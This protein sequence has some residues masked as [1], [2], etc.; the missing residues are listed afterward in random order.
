[1]TDPS[2]KLFMPAQYDVVLPLGRRDGYRAKELSYAQNLRFLQCRA[3][4]DKLDL[5]CIYLVNSHIYRR[6]FSCL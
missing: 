6:G 3:G 1:M 4:L 5:V 2:V